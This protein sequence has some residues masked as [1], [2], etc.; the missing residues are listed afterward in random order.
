MG[1]GLVW[2]AAPSL[3]PTSLMVCNP[4]SSQL[5]IP[6][7]ISEDLVCVS[8]EL[9]SAMDL[10]TVL[11]KGVWGRRNSQDWESATGELCG[12]GVCA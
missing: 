3:F 11:R 10:T 4:P 8:R 9:L 6:T 1:R 5:G 7:E 12:V 2:G